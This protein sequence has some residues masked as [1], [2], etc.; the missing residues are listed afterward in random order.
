MNKLVWLIET[1]YSAKRIS[2]N[3]LN[4]KWKENIELSGG[5]DMS[6]RTFHKW[7]LA[8]RQNFGL[9]IFC[10]QGG[11]YCYYI[12][13][14]EDLKNGSMEKW[15]LN[16]Y[17]IT[18]SIEASKSLKDR[19]LL[20][21]VPSGMKYLESIIKAMKENR[22]IHFDYFS[23]SSNSEK[24]CYVMPL[25][26]KLFRQRWYMVGRVWPAG[27]DLIFCLD[28]MHNFRLSHHTFEFPVDFSAEDY[29][30]GCFGII[31]DQNCDIQTVKLKV[32]V[33]QSNYCRDLPMHESQQEVFTTDEYSIFT[34]RVR[35]TFDFQQELLWNREELE[36][37]EP[38]W[39]R[40]KMA[41]IV[42]QMVK[43]Y[44]GKCK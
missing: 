18:N 1:I 22:Y 21:D 31:N 37:L 23:Y 25:C 26:V 33:R 19:I 10:E 15:L 17:A 40:K 14:I 41:G 12:D 20:E 8:I 29:F 7:R 3:E 6:K 24:P 32:S 36:V 35:P 42:K 16:T 4:E 43:K 39:L 2:F 5:D 44:E 9:D 34:V 28:R 11:D 38:L 27:V 13:N 30:H